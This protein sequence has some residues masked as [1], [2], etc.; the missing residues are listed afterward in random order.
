MVEDSD[1]IRRA[2][3]RRIKEI[4][5][6]RASLPPSRRSPNNSTPLVAERPPSPPV[7]P[8]PPRQ[9][10]EDRREERKRRERERERD[11]VPVREEDIAIEGSGRW[12]RTGRW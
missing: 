11:R 10:R 3:R 5:H 1:N 6:E 9:H 12:A 4:Q 2:R 8:S 7:P